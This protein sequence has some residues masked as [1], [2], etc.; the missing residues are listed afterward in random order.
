MSSATLPFLVETSALE[1]AL[2]NSTPRHVAHFQAEVAGELRTSVYIRKEFLRRWFCDMVRLALTIA[3]CGSVAD[4]LSVVSQD[5]GRGA[6]SALSAISRHLRDQGVIENEA[7]AAEEVASLAYRTLLLFDRCFP[8]RIP[9]DC[10]CQIGDR[11]PDVDCNHL[12]DDLQRF[13]ADFVQPVLQ[14]PINGY[15]DLGNPHS[16]AQMLIHHERAKKLDAV[17]NLRKLAEKGTMIT[18]RECG[19]IGDAVIALEQP[20]SA[21]LVHID[22]AFN[23]LCPALDREH[24]SLK[25]LLAIEKEQDKVDTD[26]A[27]VA[28]SPPVPPS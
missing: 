18:C 20:P 28:E 21:C 1:P 15:L 7:S 6:K 8:V 3:Q 24:K 22:R 26:N 19:S 16:R 12:L 4:A 23:T 5:F 25:S 17:E 9:N 11:S 14:C 2:G 10:H 27:I 13:Y